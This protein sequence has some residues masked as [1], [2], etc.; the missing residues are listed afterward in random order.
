MYHIFS[1][2]RKE[3]IKS[4]QASRGANAEVETRVSYKLIDNN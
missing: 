1:N 3:G 4:Q 2:H